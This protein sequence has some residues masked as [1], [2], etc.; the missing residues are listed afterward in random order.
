MH[1]MAAPFTFI[2]CVCN[3]ILAL[4]CMNEKFK[5]YYIDQF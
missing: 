4:N 5:G 2:N 3:K 1:D